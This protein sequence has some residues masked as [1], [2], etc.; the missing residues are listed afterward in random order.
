MTACH[1]TEEPP[2]ISTSLSFS[3]PLSQWWKFSPTPE[4]L[5]LSESPGRVSPTLEE[6][7]DVAINEDIHNHPA[8]K[9]YLSSENDFFH[10]RLK[11]ESRN[12]S[13]DYSASENNAFHEK[14][15]LERKN[16]S[17]QLKLDNS[18][19]KLASVRKCNKRQKIKIM[20]LKKSLKV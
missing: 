14:L 19:K 4:I 6:Q 9:N 11:L 10:E 7:S 15:K 17:F 12:A 3:P 18:Q 16:A 8:F 20:S 13:K 5:K 2:V 1:P